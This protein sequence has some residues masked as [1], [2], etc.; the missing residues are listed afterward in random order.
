MKK[1]LLDGDSIVIDG[2]EISKE[3]L[4]IY[5]TERVQYKKQLDYVKT[6][7]QGGVAS[8]Q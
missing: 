7:A 6:L 8:E 2:I 1:I 3:D 4:K 5:L